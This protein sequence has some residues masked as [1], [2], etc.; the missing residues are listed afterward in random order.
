MALGLAGDVVSV[1]GTVLM[2]AHPVAMVRSGGVGR[3]LFG[4][5][6]ALDF[7]HDAAD[8]QTPTEGITGLRL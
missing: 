5:A 8:F 1:G 6:G 3:R 7:P 2:A 4:A